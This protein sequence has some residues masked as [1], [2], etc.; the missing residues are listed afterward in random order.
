MGVIKFRFLVANKFASAASG[1]V[2][3][4]K[5]LVYSM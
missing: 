1:E 4:L 2:I 5:A 3:V